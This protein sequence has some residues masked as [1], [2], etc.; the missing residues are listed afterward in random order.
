MS[1][2]ADTIVDRRRLRRKVTFW[3]VVAILL[4]IA[5]IA[6][7]I[8]LSRPGGELAEA[9]GN[10]IARLSI[11]GLFAAMTSGSSRS[12]ASASRA[13]ARSSYT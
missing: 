8:A 11:Q 10:Y 2:D 13:C 3:R 6:A 9:S 4:V 12:T 7:A 5:G 1:L